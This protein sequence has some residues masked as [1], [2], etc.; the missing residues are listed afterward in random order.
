MHICFEC[1][2]TDVFEFCI[3]NRLQDDVVCNAYS[4]RLIRDIDFI[5]NDYFSQKE[6]YTIYVDINYVPDCRKYY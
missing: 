1:A 4:Y 2:C 3:K 6:E 5:N